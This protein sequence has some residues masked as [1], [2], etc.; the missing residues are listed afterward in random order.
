MVGYIVF[1]NQS[2]N[3][4]IEIFKYELIAVNVL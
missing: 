2:S 1:F 4:E 3:V